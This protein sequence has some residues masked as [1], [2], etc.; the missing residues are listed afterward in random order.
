MRRVR[1]TLGGVDRFYLREEEARRTLCGMGIS[2]GHISVGAD[3]AFLLPPPPPERGEFL[4]RE[5][6]IS[7]ERPLLAVALRPCET[8]E[9]IPVLLTSVRH[10]SRQLGL[11]P[12]L[13]AFDRFEDV[14]ISTVAARE[15]EGVL[16]PLREPSDAVAIL[17]CAS[18]AVVMRLHAMILSTV[19][20]I[21]ALGVPAEGKLGIFAR[22]LGQSA[23]SG[24]G[25][26]APVV[27]DALM[28]EWL[29]REHS[30]PRLLATAE[31]QRKKAVKD[32]EKLVDLIYNKGNEEFRA[33][34]GAG[35]ET[36]L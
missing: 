20:G 22:T 36:L 29:A 11:L 33:D 31:E 34:P 10:L 23:L 14:R 26:S 25:L 30:R 19:A 12:V 3:A 6:G 18:L 28:K 27:C 1:E 17:S 7:S 15:V 9:T 21:P 16:L 5:A 4:L 32:L 35:E 2:P 13:L 8:R 24:E